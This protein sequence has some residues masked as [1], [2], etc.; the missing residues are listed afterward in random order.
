MQTGEI[1]YNNTIHN[2]EFPSPEEE[3]LPSVRWGAIDAFPS[4]A[5]WAYQVKAK[6][7]RGGFVHHRLGATFREEICACLLGGY[8]IPASI[9]LAAFEH[10]KREG[11]FENNTPNLKEIVEMLSSPLK[12]QNRYVRYRFAKQKARYIH[13][14]LMKLDHE[15]PIEHN[16]KNLRN[17]LLEIPGVGF[18]TA[19]W[20]ARNWLGADDVA[21]LDIHIYRAGVIGGYLTPTKTMSKDYL[22]LEDQFITFSRALGVRTSELDAVMWQEMMT[23]PITVHKMINNSDHLSDLFKK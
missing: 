8:G 10:L 1:Y 15:E 19:S 14:A 21:I 23:S 22:C 16:G 17:W 2:I 6:Q 4:P 18:K 20:I 9:G 3:V 7:L 11:L 12:M 13:A 5:Y